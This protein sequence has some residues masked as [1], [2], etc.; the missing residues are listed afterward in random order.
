MRY[1]IKRIISV[2]LV[3][4][5]VLSVVTEAAFAAS[6]TAT[7]VTDVSKLKAGDQIIIVAAEY[8]Y[9]LGTTQNSNNRA[10]S[11]ITK[12]ADGTTVT[13][14]ADTQIIT[15]A[16]GSASGTLAFTV[17]DSSYLAASSSSSNYL[18]TVTSL[19]DNAS[20]NI[21][22]D[23]ATGVA[24]I[25]S[26]GTYSRNTLR[27]NSSSTLFSCYAASNSQ[28]DVCIYL[29]SSTSGDSDSGSSG[30]T[31]SSNGNAALITSTSSLKVGAQILVVAAESD[32][33]LSN[34]QNTNNRGQA[35]VVK[36]SDKKTL[37]AYSDAQVITLQSG[38]VSGT[39]SLTVDDGYLYA[40]A[41]SANHLKTASSQSAN[42]DWTISI[43]ASTG[44]ATVVGAG[45]Y[46]RNHLRHNASGGL[47]SCYAENN[48]VQDISLY[49]V[50]GALGSGNT[51]G[52]TG[53]SVESSTDLGNS[54][55]DC[56]H[57]CSNGSCTDC[58]AAYIL[59]TSTPTG[60]TSA[61]QVQYVTENGY[62]V[63]WGARGEDAKF[64]STY[65]SD[66][67]S[68]NYAYDVMSKLSGGTSTS[69]AAS[70]ALYSSLQSLMESNHSAFTR[71]SSTN[72][73]D[74][75]NF[76][77]YTDCL[78]SDTAHVST[79]YRG[80]LVTGPWGSGEY[81][82]EHVWPNSKCTGSN[83]TDIGDIMNLRPANY[84]ENSSR[85]NTAYGE[86]D[87][88]YDPGQSV[89][90]DC[91]RTLLYMYTRWGNTAIWGT[92]GVIE[93]VDILLKWITEDPV[94]TWEMGHN[95]AVQ[96]I[97]GTRNVFVD[98]PEYAFLLFGEDIPANLVSP[99][100]GN[101][102]AD[103]ST[104]STQTT[105]LYFNSNDYGW[106]DVSIYTWDAA[107]N[108]PTGV[109]PGAAMTKI[110]DGIYSYPVPVTATNV[111]FTDGTSQSND[112]TI[113]TDGTNYYSIA[114]RK[115]TVYGEVINYYLFGYINGANYGTEEDSANL[116]TY[117][118]VDGKLTATFDQDSYVAVKTDNNNWYMFQSYVTATSGTLYNT[119]S[120][121]YEKMLVPGSVELTFTLTVNNDDTLSLSYVAAECDHSYTSSVT[122]AATCT[123]AGVRTYTCSKCADTYTQTIAAT[124]HSYSGGTCTACGALDP[125]F[126]VSDTGFVQVT[127]LSAITAGGNFVLVALV[128]GSYKALDTTL[129]SGKVTAVDVNVANRVVTGD[130]VPVWTIAA[131]DGGVSLSVD[132]SYLNYSS[133]TNFKFADTAYTWTVTAGDSGY[134]F[135][136]SATTRGI[137]YQTSSNKFGAYS[138]TNATASGYVS[139]LLVFKY[140]VGTQGCTHSYK[141]EV[142]TAATCLADGVK[143][144][145]CTLC[146]DLYTES[147]PATGHDYELTVVA[148]TC[149]NN[150]Y[151][152]H[153]C[154]NCSYSY[155][156]TA[157]NP[158]GH[159]Y[160]SVVTAPTCTEKGYTTYTCSNCGNVYTWNE[161]AA[162]GH[163]YVNGTCTACG[164]I[165]P[166]YS[167]SE[168]IYYL[169]GIG[170]VAYNGYD[171]PFVD[172]K[173]TLDVA[174][175]SYV[176]VVDNYGV[177]YKTDG[178]QGEVSSVTLMHESN[179]TGTPDKLM[180]PAGVVTLTLTDNGD[181]TFT[182]S[183]TLD[184]ESSGNSTDYYLVGYINGAN[185]GCEED[186]ENLGI[187]KF[188]NGSLTAT[189]EQDSYV[190]IKTGDNTK[191]YMLPAYDDDGSASF[192]LT[193]TGTS[194][195]MFVPG[196]VEVIFS[197]TE[198][199]DDSLIVTYVLNEG[200][201]HATHDTDGICVSCGKNVGHNMAMGACTICGKPCTHNYVSGGFCDI[202]G[203]QLPVYYYLFGYINGANYGCEEDAATWGEYKFVDGKLTAKFTQDSYVA[204]KDTNGVWYMCE[205]Y[206]ASLTSR[207]MYSASGLTN[208]DKLFVPGGVTVTFTLE[209][210]SNRV[211]LSYTTESASVVTPTLTLKN[212]TLAFED[213]ILYNVY[214][215]VDNMDSVTEMG[216]VTYATRNENGTVADALDTIPGYVSN[217]DG[218][219]TIHS[220]GI[221][222]KMLG[223]ALYFKAYAKLTDG[224]YVYSGIAGYH[225]VLYANTVLNSDATSANAKSL[226]VAM[227]NYGA[228]AQV[229]F[230]Y[231][232]D[233]LMNANLT[234]D[235]K[236][237]VSAY[238]ESMIAAVPSVSTT[239][240][241]SFVNNGGYSD[242]HPTV[243]FE[244]AFSINYYFT[245]KYTPDSN[246]VVFYYWDLDAFNGADVLS[247]SNAIGT[248]LMSSTTG[249]YSQAINDIAA[250]AI[251]EPVYV[252]AM[253]TSGGT[254]YTTPVIGYSLGAYCKNIAANG[255][256]F[257][258]A[259]AV[260]GYYA[261]A[262]FAS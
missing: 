10:P 145:T 108:E 175:T 207:Y 214:F 122:T 152:I 215:N 172:G 233:S 246:T 48:S 67:Y 138:T 262:Y 230:E 83:S 133:S 57:D 187:Y 227:L 86:S 135:N 110:S 229:S 219:Y 170:G 144:Y 106:G 53:G 2:L 241:G 116:G 147:I 68:G 6:G 129:T 240:A 218:T 188:V 168:T 104:G 232:T 92:D 173:I 38:T 64:L 33:C 185:Y 90:G 238:S 61:S 4:S 235:Q 7:L 84:S 179:V 256:D 209:A 220:N 143:T 190:F 103:N 125:N 184:E 98:Y 180:I 60:Y 124:G 239:K 100:S 126:V 231:K 191:W 111:I 223:D 222:A 204:V 65:G 136:S 154:K 208:P 49:E 94:D 201:D 132:G 198:N 258:A 141:S 24:A 19:T 47:F 20:W 195:K 56:N 63:N 140:Q 18:K 169:F 16:N 134:V 21:T 146:G 210:Y 91:A 66:F 128:D 115:W 39:W 259:T 77:Q 71:Y 54:D 245:P 260:Y 5:L 212:P 131:V 95:D 182:L 205:G 163:S 244:G 247:S 183:Y 216:M 249:V 75:K 85:G 29:V 27:Y 96:S 193:S 253:Y 30:S 12:S 203:D 31:G 160:S 105:M 176:W 26:A 194:E 189:F 89:R 213:E 150:G 119:T 197:L 52:S 15:L 81:N 234:S 167:E 226:V 102:N 250:K 70:S 156:D 43:D 35:D 248:Y 17:E 158:I 62:V 171:H 28:K 80:L 162:T 50:T 23:S 255:N 236:A 36:S 178:W 200:C 37:T 196:G 174:V 55:S 225:A 228:A 217:D 25:V 177:A 120:G 13:L 101:V 192:Y 224:S 186:Y 34:V 8:D 153:A 165:D 42:T 76:Y 157:V 73:M 87:G 155:N 148:P 151:T 159:N 252:A 237:L 243:S 9:A 22:I 14:G 199:W 72:T 79:I 3:L 99:T 130:S 117:L 121:V 127:D 51:G 123:S 137:Y 107:G 69:N 93:S 44:I 82:Q 257:G 242:V 59:M 211:C 41:S 149:E 11:A 78:R 221:P 206:D 164:Q 254:T 142:T 202:C 45:E 74:C 251:D 58:G 97:T 113:P 112:L 166:D 32:Y 88:Y 109:W 161:T 118:F 40:A 139:E 261:K 46:T 114:S 1:P 181:T